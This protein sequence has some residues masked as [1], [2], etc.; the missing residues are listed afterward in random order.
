MDIY[1]HRGGLK[2]TLRATQKGTLILGFIGGS[3]TDGRPEW[4][5]PEAVTAWFVERFPG[6]EEWEAL[7]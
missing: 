4:N 3:I 1:H 7:R 2:H 6:P 5:W